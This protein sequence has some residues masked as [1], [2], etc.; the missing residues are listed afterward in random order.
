MNIIEAM[1]K[2]LTEFLYCFYDEVNNGRIHQKV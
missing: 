1:A 2:Y